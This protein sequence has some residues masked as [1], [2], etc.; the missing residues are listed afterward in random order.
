MNICAGIRDFGNT[1]SDGISWLCR[2][3]HP[4]AKVAK[5]WGTHGAKDEASTV[6]PSFALSLSTTIEA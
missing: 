5:G 6:V 4:F 3:S 1:A 2:F